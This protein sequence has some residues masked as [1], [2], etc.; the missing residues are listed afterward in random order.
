LLS[1][2]VRVQNHLGPTVIPIIE[3]GVGFR[4]LAQRQ[5]VRNDG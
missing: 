1:M 4:C 5:L 3:V 2:G